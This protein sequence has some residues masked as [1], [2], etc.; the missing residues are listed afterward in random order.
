M[1]KPTA[2]TPVTGAEALIRSLISQGVDRVFGYPGGAIMPVYDCL[3]SHTA[4]IVHVLTRHEQ[5]AIHAAQGYARITGRPGVVIV[6]SGPGATNVM[7]GIADA[8]MDSTP[9]V[10]IMGQIKAD[11]LGNDAFQETDVVSMTAPIT[12][13]GIQ[14]R[15]ADD[16][17]SV[18][19]K[20]YYIASTGRPG[21]VVIDFAKNAQEELTN[22]TPATCNY[23]R[24]YIPDPDPDSEAVCRAAALLNRARR[25]LILSGHGV[26]I[27]SAEPELIELA[28][29]AE[30]PVASTLLG[31]STMP[32]DHRLFR[33]MIGMHGHVGPNYNTNRA[34]VILA[35]G[36]RFD[37]R[38]TGLINDYAPQAQIIH[39]DIDESEFN[40]NVP[41]DV[42][43][44]GDVRRVLRMLLPLIE[45]ARHTRW[46][47][48]F[49]EIDRVEEEKVILPEMGHGQDPQ[50]RPHMGEV[51]RAVSE[52]A[53]PN[54]VLV[55]D[56]GQNQMLSA[57][58]F[59][60]RGPRSI[61]TS[62][63]LGTMG[64][65]IPAAIGAKMADPTRNVCLFTGDGGF[66]MTIQELGTIMQYGVPVK[67]TILNNSFLGNVRQWQQMFYDGRF[68]QTPM[69]NPD[70]VSI[71]SAYG[72][73]GCHVH[74]RAELPDAIRRMMETP[75][76]F[77]MEV[78]IDEH[79]MIFPMT[80]AGKPVD[81]IM[82][83]LDE[84]F[85]SVH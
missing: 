6:T 20:A 40:K 14:V 59:R 2:D 37:D 32:S 24:S 50:A 63:G 43:I 72:I 27:S 8:L 7:T 82:L 62:G 16:I 12:K 69:I 58:Y 79:D 44:W 74:S 33:G 77:V 30:I 1:N 29:K 4:D 36:L 57:R 22:W 49:D 51:A 10:V 47:S 9:L 52:A 64:F 45:T 23:I 65:G 34:D 75:G 11:L 31:L 5:G 26:M 41:A 25:P 17:A 15:H 71:A 13:W 35:L 18:V 70:F 46:I 83:N 42:T 28:E 80:P 56:V 3:Y 67:I 38:V 73:E 48:S 55:T 53:G 85:A 39:V 60:Y 19:A 68:S 66:Q 54:P 76:A 84:T 61:I 21:P 81:H 78:D